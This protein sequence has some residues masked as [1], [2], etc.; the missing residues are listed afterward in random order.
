MYNFFKCPKCGQAMTLPSCACN[1]TVEYKN[2]I[3]QLTDM[4][5]IVKD[6]S[7]GVSYI[8]YEEIGEYYSGKSLFD[9]INI[10]RIYTKTAEI[11]GDGVL[12]DLACGD[13]LFTVP[14]VLQN[15]SVISMDISD[16]MLSL[17][18]KRA[19][20]AEIEPSRFTVCRANALNIPLMDNS[21]D[22]VI[23]NSMLHLIS[24]PEIVIEEIHRVLK[25]GGKFI[26]YED[27]PGKASDERG[28]TE[29]ETADNKKANEFSGYIYGRYFD[30]LKDEYNIHGKRYSWNFDREKICSE[31][32]NDKK[33]YAVENTTNKIKRK[34][35]DASLYRMGGKGFSDQSDVPNDIHKS[36]FERV[37]TEFISI[38]GNEA[39]DTIQTFYA[40]FGDMDIIV[41]IK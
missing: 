10:D 36:V 21:V 41:Y 13:G 5:Y 33:I 1:Y 31:T 24:K 16:K 30:I 27:K 17:L 14:L 40:G 37:K 39:L 12:L 19:E 2:R 6:N 18:Y 11:I 26:T 29:E 34:L 4:P 22:A 9:K 3:Y 35:R 32:F 23:A 38:Y 25:K 7:A 8:G 28:F 15:I 20:I